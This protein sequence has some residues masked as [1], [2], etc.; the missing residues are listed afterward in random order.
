MHSSHLKIS[1]FTSSCT[2]L[3][4]FLLPSFSILLPSNFLLQII[5]LHLSSSYSLPSLP[6]SFLHFLLLL[7]SSLLIH[8]SFLNSLTFPFP[9]PL[10]FP[11]FPSSLLFLHFSFPSISF[12]LLYPFLPFLLSYFLSLL[13]LHTSFSSPSPLT[14]SPYF[15]LPLFFPFFIFLIIF[16]DSLL[17]SHLFSHFLILLILI[18]FLLFPPFSI[19]HFSLPLLGPWVLS[20]AVPRRGSAMPLGSARRCSSAAAARSTVAS[21]PQGASTWRPTGRPSY[22]AYSSQVER[23]K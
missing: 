22:A 17:F 14:L 6:L 18:S 23:K 20:S 21:A 13:L 3:P 11:Y 16:L 9:L 12:I 19:L 7:F 8:F 4:P 2:N 10:T 1:I 15:P 5:Y